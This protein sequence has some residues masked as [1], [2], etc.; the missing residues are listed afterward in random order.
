MLETSAVLIFIATAFISLVPGQSPASSPEF[1]SPPYSS[2]IKTYTSSSINNFKIDFVGTPVVEE[3]RGVISNYVARL[4]RSLMSVRVIQFSKSEL[5]RVTSSEML[6]QVKVAYG[7]S[8][9]YKILETFRDEAATIDFLSSNETTLRRVRAHLVGDKLFE[10][11][12]ELPQFQR[13]KD[14]HP[15]RLAAFSREA[16]RFFNSFEIVKKKTR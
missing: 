1:W 12:V 11:Y 2:D 5:E 3:G 16:D 15:E 4:P 13:L 14:V 10:L 6:G 8:Q 7:T 9:G